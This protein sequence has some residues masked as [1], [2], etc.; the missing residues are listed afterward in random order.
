MLATAILPFCKLYALLRNQVQVPFIG[1]KKENFVYSKYFGK[2]L[3]NWK[4]SKC[5]TWTWT[6]RFAGLATCPRFSRLFH[7]I[8]SQ[9]YII[10][11]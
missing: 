11:F 10:K 1:P 4:Y 3:T 7:K 5:W 2:K 6:W 8:S 9:E